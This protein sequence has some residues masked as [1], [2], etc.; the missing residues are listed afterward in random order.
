MKASGYSLRA[1]PCQDTSARGRIRALKGKLSRDFRVWTM[2]GDR[3]RMQPQGSWGLR[4][5]SGA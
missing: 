1:R 2:A 3:F 5:S 4:F